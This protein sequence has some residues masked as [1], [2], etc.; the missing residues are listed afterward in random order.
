M[1]KYTETC[2]IVR[3][4]RIVFSD[5]MYAYT[6]LQCFEA[7]GEERVKNGAHTMILVFVSGMCLVMAQ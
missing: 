7:G 2:S 5:Y 3:F 1:V 6:L 4:N